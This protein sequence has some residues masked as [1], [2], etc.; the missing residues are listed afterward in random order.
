MEDTIQYQCEALL[1]GSI[2]KICYF[3]L[4]EEI[5]IQ[6]LNSQLSNDLY[7]SRNLK[8]FCGDNLHSG[9]ISVLFETQEMIDRRQL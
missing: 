7:L 5:L 9:A 1:G 3:Y 8:S 2:R 6:Y 4:L